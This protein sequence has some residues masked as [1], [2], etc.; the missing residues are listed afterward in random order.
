[1]SINY[2]IWKRKKSLRSK[3]YNN[4][5]LN[6]EDELKSILYQ[7]EERINELENRLKEFTQNSAY[8]VKRENMKESLRDTEKGSLI[9]NK[10]CKNGEKWEKKEERK[11][12]VWIGNNRIFQNCRKLRF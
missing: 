9:P 11:G 4:W 12:N 6:W 2:Q 1:M 7:T 3:N 5:N 8:W 10:H